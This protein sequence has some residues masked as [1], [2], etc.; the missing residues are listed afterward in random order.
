MVAMGTCAATYAL[1]PFSGALP[2]LM[3]IAF[4]LGTGPG[5]G[6]PLLMAAMHG[7]APA[8]RGGET[9]GLRMTLQSTQQIVLPV[10]LGLLGT[11]LGVSPLFWLYSGLVAAVML[12]MRG[13]L[14]E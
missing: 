7:A 11:V 1:R 5:I 4:M 10:L 12:S 9:A 14:G 8:G 6:Q 13:K 3:A 2:V